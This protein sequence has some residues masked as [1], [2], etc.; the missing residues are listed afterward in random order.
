MIVNQMFVLPTE[1]TLYYLSQIFSGCPFDIDLSLM[2]VEVNS[3]VQEM[4]PDPLLLYKAT[5]GTMEV[6]FDTAT[7]ETSLLLPL[8]SRSLVERCAELRQ[9]APS[10]F[11]S[12]STMGEDYY[13]PFMVVKRNMP[14]RSRH[15]RSFINSLSNTL[16][17]TSDY[18]LL[19]EGEFI[20]TSDFSNVPDYDYYSSQV[21]NHLQVTSSSKLH[22]A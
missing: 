14:P 11:Y 7:M 8:E 20:V 13:F 15:Y 1:D 10:A 17:T 5:A 12:N 19:F 2:H 9:T 21:G 4:T 6:F 3:S 16:A 22:R 18:P